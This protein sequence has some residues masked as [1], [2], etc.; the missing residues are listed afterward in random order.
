MV[1]KASKKE[2]ICVLPFIEKMSVQLQTRSANLKL[3]SKH[4]AN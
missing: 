2:L 4:H 3:L 1:L